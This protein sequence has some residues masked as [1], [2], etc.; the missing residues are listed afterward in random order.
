MLTFFK[1]HSYD[2]VKM[3]INQFDISIFGNALALATGETQATLRIATS[4]FSILFYL[5]LIYVMMWDLGAKDAR[6]LEKKDAGYTYAT[7]IYIA[8]F[9]SIPNLIL[10]LLIALGTWVSSLGNMGAVAKLIAL[11]CEGMYTG[12][13]AI[14]VGGTPLNNLWFVFFLL[15][16]PLIV[17]S[18]IAY[19]AGSQ[20]FKVFRTKR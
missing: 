2:V 4:I 7:G 14:T 17:T 1:K 5:F 13:L 6:H 3:F 9:A 8:L 12:L 11:F 16:I 20:D 10:A 18:G 19:Y 15:P